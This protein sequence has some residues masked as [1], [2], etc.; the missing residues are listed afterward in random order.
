MNQLAMLQKMEDEIAKLEQIEKEEMCHGCYIFVNDREENSKKYVTDLLKPYLDDI[1]PYEI[2][3]LEN[4][5]QEYEE[6]KE[7][8]ENVDEYCKKIYGGYI[9]NEKVMSTSNYDS[10]MNKYFIK[11]DYFV[12]ELDTIKS[13]IVLDLVFGPD[14]VI[15]EKGKDDTFD[16]KLKKMCEDYPNY[17][18][19]YIEYHE[20]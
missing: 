6:D 5:K 16:E 15:L 19:V 17:L 13:S 20:P 3:T 7:F 11:G 1:E 12:H 9:Q 4:I 8:Y 2:N 10:I 14:G 18:V